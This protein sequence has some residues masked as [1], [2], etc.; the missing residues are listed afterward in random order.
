[1]SSVC[2]SIAIIY[3]SICLAIYYPASIFP[4]S[5]LSPSL[6]LS[7]S[8]LPASSYLPSLLSPFLSSDK[9]GQPKVLPP[10]TP[11]VRSWPSASILSAPFSSARLP[12]D[13]P[14][15][16]SWSRLSNPLWSL[17][18]WPVLAPPCPKEERSPQLLLLSG[19]LSI[20]TGWPTPRA[21]GLPAVAH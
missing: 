2:L 6:P 3:L 11:S 14:S 8:R 21:S 7:S 17:L 19:S 4:L 15:L 10:Y 12:S 5:L 20:L 9:H 18:I 1:M 13:Y 16:I